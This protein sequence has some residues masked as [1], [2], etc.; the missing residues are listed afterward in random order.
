MTVDNTDLR[1]PPELDGTDPPPDDDGNGC[2]PGETVRTVEDSVPAKT[3][4]ANGVCSNGDATGA[5][6]AKTSRL[7]LSAGLHRRLNAVVRDR[8]IFFTKR[9]RSTSVKS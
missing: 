7:S 5:G 6:G 2:F 4:K 9:D 3:S 1:S 8:I